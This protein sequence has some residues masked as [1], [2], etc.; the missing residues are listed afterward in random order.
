MDEP[1]ARDEKIERGTRPKGPKRLS[2]G[3]DPTILEKIWQTLFELGHYTVQDAKVLR[4][5]Q[6]LL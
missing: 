2:T 6:D 1:D 5:Y 4:G 3:Q